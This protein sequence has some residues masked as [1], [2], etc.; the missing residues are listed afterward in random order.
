MKL[1]ARQI[2]TAWHSVTDEWIVRRNKGRETKQWE[3]VHDWG[4]DVVS[5]DTRK[6]LRRFD[7]PRNAD[8]FAARCEDEARG[9]AVLALIGQVL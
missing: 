6:V 7:I 4:G 5:E 3:V 1:T 9:K 2:A 8:D